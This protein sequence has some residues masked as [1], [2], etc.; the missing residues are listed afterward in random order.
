MKRL[1]FLLLIAFTPA[2]ALT[3]AEIQQH[4]DAAIKADGGE[5]VL[6]PG[7][8][9][10]EK[11]LLLQDAKK[12]RLI[13]LDAETCILQAAPGNTSLLRLDGACEAVRIEKLTFAGGQDGISEEKTGKDG[14]QQIHIGRCFFQNQQRH[15]VR[16]THASAVEIE[17]CT[18][19]DIAKDAVVFGGQVT[20]SFIAHNHLTRCAVG[21]TLQG[22][23][24]CLVASNELSD[25]RLG[26]LITGASDQQS[27]DQGNGIALNAIMRSAENAIQFTSHTR[28]NSVLQNE[29][30]GSGKHGIHLAGEGQT[31]KGNK[32]SGS[33]G[34][35]VF[36]EAGKHEVVE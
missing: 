27:V 6:P 21:V 34:K 26:I 4:I 7:V 33:Q 23:Q 29:I 5:V 31:V 11:G 18:F 2:H 16:V 32:I 35:D 9:V 36:T 19:R 8:H 13:G 30:T 15:A 22:A 1:L 24:K 12:L 28:N 25:C 3:E 14:L 20:G 17:D 10:I